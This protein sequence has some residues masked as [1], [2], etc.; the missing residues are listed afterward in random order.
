MLAQQ[1]I[2]HAHMRASL[3]RE[4]HIIDD[5]YQLRGEDESMHVDAFA[6]GGSSDSALH[7]GKEEERPGL[8]RR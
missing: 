5:L 1:F 6:A 4:C 2:A 8:Q 3:R 7:R